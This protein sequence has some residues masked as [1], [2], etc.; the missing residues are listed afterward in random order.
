M[1]FR[2]SDTTRRMF[3]WTIELGEY[4]IE[5]QLR[6]SIKDKALASLADFVLECTQS[7]KSPGQDI[8]PPQEEATWTFMT[9]GSSTETNDGAK[10]I[11]YPP[12]RE[13]LK[14]AILLPSQMKITR[15]SMRHSLL[16][17]R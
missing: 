12:T 7:Q 4:D 5:F 14:Y 9:D 15:R 10:I 11:L 16:Y 1:I 17:S 13:L 6:P 8:D 3:R 2:K